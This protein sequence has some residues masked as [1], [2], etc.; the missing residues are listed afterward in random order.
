MDE[1]KIKIVMD[2][3]QDTVQLKINYYKPYSIYDQ[4][5]GRAVFLDSEKNIGVDAT[6]AR[7]YLQN[8]NFRLGFYKI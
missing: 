4:E 7:V 8:D 1:S 3:D 2:S 5:D 6:Q